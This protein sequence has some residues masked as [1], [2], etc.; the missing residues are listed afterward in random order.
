MLTCPSG[1]RATASPPKPLPESA[2]HNRRRARFTAFCGCEGLL[3]NQCPLWARSGQLRRAAVSHT[4]S[5]GAEAGAL[6][7]HWRPLRPASPSGFP[8]C[9]RWPA[10][11]PRRGRRR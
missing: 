8:G 2:A 1:F 10:R 9:R 5:P 7:F 3:S 11:G 6:F 4:K